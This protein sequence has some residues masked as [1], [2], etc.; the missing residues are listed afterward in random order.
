L[1]MASPTLIRPDNDIT[2]WV[3]SDFRELNKWIVRQPYPIPTISTTLQELEDFSYATALDLN[4]FYYTIRLDSMVVKMCT[5]IFPL[6]K[7]TY[8][9]L[10]ME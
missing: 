3:I 8:L 6:G 10:L 9:R 1:Q 4:M 2:V 7:Y 5:I